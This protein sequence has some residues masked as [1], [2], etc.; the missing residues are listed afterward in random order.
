MDYNIFPWIVLGCITA[1]LIY[2]GYIAVYENRK[3]SKYLA[4]K[5]QDV[6][7]LIRLLSL[8]IDIAAKANAYL[9]TKETSALFSLKTSLSEFEK[10]EKK[11]AE[12]LM[13]MNNE[14]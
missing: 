3:Y 2:N 4:S 9:K 14:L 10:E 8:S 6:R 11:V 13:E 5:V 1:V 7:R 12:L